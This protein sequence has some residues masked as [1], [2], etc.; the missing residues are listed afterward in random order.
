MAGLLLPLPPHAMEPRVVK[1]RGR[2]AGCEDL[3][4]D[5]TGDAVVFKNDRLYTQEQMRE[6]AEACVQAALATGG[7]R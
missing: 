1:G 3:V 7:H 4:A 2:R 5:P 6:Y